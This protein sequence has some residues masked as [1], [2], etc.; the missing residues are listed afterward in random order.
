MFLSHLCIRTAAKR[1]IS[2]IILFYRIYSSEASVW[3]WVVEKFNWEAHLVYSA[4]DQLPLCFA[5]YILQNSLWNSNQVIY[6][7]GIIFIF[8]YC[9]LGFI[10]ATILKH[11]F[12]KHLKLNS[13][14]NLNIP[15]C[16]S[17]WD[18][19]IPICISFIS[20]FCM[21]QIL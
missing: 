8:W 18:V 15:F 1:F 16:L 14:L 3:I 5:L 10:A 7:S 19:P 9:H 20:P 2:E 21:P 6:W 17:S 4:Q 13:S 11:S 12:F